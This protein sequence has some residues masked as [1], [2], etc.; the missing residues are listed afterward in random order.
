[1]LLVNTQSFFYNPTH[2]KTV[3]NTKTTIGI[4]AAVA[5]L[6]VA[7]A[8]APLATSADA[9]RVMTCTNGGGHIKDCTSPAGKECTVKAGEGQGGGET[10]DC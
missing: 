1:M 4:F 3:M 10:K 7:L 8:L 2:C 6:A 9:A 5:V